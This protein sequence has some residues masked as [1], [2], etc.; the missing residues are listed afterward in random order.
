M[1]R[2][3]IPLEEGE[4]DWTMRGDKGSQLA[5]RHLYAARCCIPP[6]FALIQPIPIQVIN[7]MSDF[8]DKIG[9]FDGTSDVQ[10]VDELDRDG[11]TKESFSPHQDVT[12]SLIDAHR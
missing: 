11:S 7:P 4:S 3:V 8:K 9:Q 1:R 12:T 10:P 2:L 5:G 6:I